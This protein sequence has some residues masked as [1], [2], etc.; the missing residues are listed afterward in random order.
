ME[1]GKNTVGI[2]YKIKNSGKPIKL[3]LAPIVNFRDFHSMSTDHIFNIRQEIKDKKVK[4]IIDEKPQTPVYMNISEG[5]YIKHENDTFTNMLYI[6]EEKRGF[7]PKENHSV[8][9]VYQIEIEPNEEKEISK[10]LSGSSAWNRR[11]CGRLFL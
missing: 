9:G 11:I 10:P 1:Y 5:S 3:N 8:P 2:Q 7:Y 6:E 4:L